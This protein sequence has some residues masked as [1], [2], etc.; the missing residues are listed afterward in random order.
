[1]E[2][3][4]SVISNLIQVERD[5]VLFKSIIVNEYK[6]LTYKSIQNRDY[7]LFSYL[8]TKLTIYKIEDFPEDFQSEES[9]IKICKNYM[10]AW[11]NDFEKF[12]ILS[13]GQLED[14]QIN[15]NLCEF[16]IIINEKDFTSVPDRYK[17]EE[18]C[19]DALKNGIS[20][21]DIPEDLITEEIIKVAIIHDK[22][23]MDSV[24]FH[25][26]TNEMCLWAVENG[27]SL[28]YIF[29]DMITE[30]IAKI[31]IKKSFR[32]M[33]YVPENLLTEE[34]YLWAVKNGVLL[35]E[36][37]KEKITKEIATESLKNENSGYHTLISDRVKKEEILLA[38]NHGASL[39][40]VP[41]DM[42]T[43][44]MVKNFRRVKAYSTV[45]A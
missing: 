12:G 13:D 7:A 11:S 20:L 16:A 2:D 19:I 44:E 36:V 34:L 31:A 14:E 45:A 10:D 41:D 9:F 24:P 17:S 8:L 33:K 37:P 18:M 1:M 38:V 15:E 4:K 3:I 30:E 23:A 6:Y 5:R 32:E 21:Y 28:L 43:E 40:Y 29:E 35:S 39:K 22:L 26:M 25:F 42:I 27:V